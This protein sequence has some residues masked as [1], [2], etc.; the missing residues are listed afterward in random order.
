MDRNRR[1]AWDAAFAKIA[2]GESISS[3][4][5]YALLRPGLFEGLN[6][7]E[8]TAEAANVVRYWLHGMDWSPIPPRGRAEANNWF[9]MRKIWGEKRQAEKLRNMI[10]ASVS[11]LDYWDALNLI[12]VRLL[13]NSLPFPDDLADWAIEFHKGA[14]PPP[15]HHRGTPRYANLNRDNMIADVFGLLGYLGLDRKMVRYNVLESY[16]DVDERTVMSAIKADARFD[17]KLPPPWKCWPS[18]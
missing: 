14:S 4:E 7:V 18:R 12:S 15:K 13:A 8:A 2:N 3:A 1:A 9:A 16:F 10:E 17:R 6:D 5:H 11:D